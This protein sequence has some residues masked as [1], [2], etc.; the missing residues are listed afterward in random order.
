MD[1]SFTV[2]PGSVV[3]PDGRASFVRGRLENLL[4]LSRMCVRSVSVEMSL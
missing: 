1:G 4:M 2:C 3:G